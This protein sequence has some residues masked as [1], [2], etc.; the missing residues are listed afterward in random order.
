ME[1]EMA[2]ALEEEALAD[3]DVIMIKTIEELNGQ[4]VACV[5]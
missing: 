1:L 2:I 4:M 5:I 3:N